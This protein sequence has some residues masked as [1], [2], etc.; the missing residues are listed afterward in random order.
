MNSTTVL[1]PNEL[2]IRIERTFDALRAHVFSV[3]TDP[4]L[5]PEWWG[6]GTVVEKMDVRPGV[7]AGANNGFVR[8]RRA[9]PAA[10]ARRVGIQKRRNEASPMKTMTCRQLGGPCDFPHH[11]QT[12]NQAIKAQDQH[13][14]DVVAHGDAVHDPA[15]REMQGRWKHPIS[16]MGWYRKAKRDFAALP[17]D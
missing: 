3:Y 12:A 5:I 6:E 15:L 17:E 11:G 14:K 4:K 1:T 9:A 8:I 13:L 2:E 10:T 7:K 16:G